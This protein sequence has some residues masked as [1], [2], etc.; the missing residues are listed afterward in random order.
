MKEKILVY[1]KNKKIL[2]VLCCVALLSPL[3]IY[4]TQFGIGV[5]TD[6]SEWALMGTAIGGIYSPILAIATLALLYKQYQLQRSISKS[7]NMIMMCSDARD[8]GIYLI[9]QLKDSLLHTQNNHMSPTFYD[10]L[11]K[12][13]DSGTEESYDHVW[14]T[15]RME[16][17][18]FRDLFLLLH[19]LNNTDHV[20]AKRLY[21]SLKTKMIGHLSIEICIQFEFYYKK[22]IEDYKPLISEYTIRQETI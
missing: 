8:D 4:A 10:V 17:F 21:Y 14:R 9:S 1:I 13:K 16:V 6:H 19:M 11:T 2:L 20:V 3:V 12:Y 7:Q 5:W 22:G 18:L 15:F